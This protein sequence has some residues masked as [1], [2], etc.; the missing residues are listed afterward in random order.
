MLI[1]LIGQDQYE[2]HSHYYNNTIS[3]LC[4]LGRGKHIQT[5]VL[6]LIVS[7]FDNIF[8]RERQAIIYK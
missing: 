4:I 7:K 3:Y 5:T 2:Q 1:H 8:R 6:K